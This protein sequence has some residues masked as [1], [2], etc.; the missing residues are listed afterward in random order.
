MAK[1]AKQLKKKEGMRKTQRQRG[2]GWTDLVDQKHMISPGNQT[3]QPY[4]GPMKDCAGLP[5]RPGTIA[6]YQSQGLPGWGA[7]GGGKTQRRQRQRKQ[8]G[9]RGG[10]EVGPYP[11][12]YK[13][14]P[15]ALKY[16]EA[17]YGNTLRGGRWGSF[18]EVGPL[19]PV[20]AVGAASY[21]PI[22]RVPCEVGTQNALNPNPGGVQT[23]STAVGWQPGWTPF[24]GGGGCACGLGLRAGGSMGTRRRRQRGGVQVGEV[25]AMRYYAPTAG[26]GN[27]PL[28]PQVQNNPG[29]LMQ[30]GYPAR[31]FNMACMKTN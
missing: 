1:G 5:A 30:V 2:A 17:E 8:K 11:A 9:Q 14:V 16:S 4:P 24:R 18:P 6:A 7:A 20:N 12:V 21:A 19:N 29:V 31:H 27:Y 13:G 3:H 10:L 28:E 25:D 15:I 22:G 26:Y 23:M